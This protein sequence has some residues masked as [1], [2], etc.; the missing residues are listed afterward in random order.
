MN[1]P[2]RMER[3]TGPSLTKLLWRAKTRMAFGSHMDGVEKYAT[4]SNREC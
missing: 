3:R 4:E 1:L 2:K